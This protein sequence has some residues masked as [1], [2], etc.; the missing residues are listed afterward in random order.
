LALAEIAGM[1]AASDPDRAE[2]LARSI[3]DAYYKSL[4]LAGIARIWLQ[5]P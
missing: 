3:T 4:A 5:G 1:L 2:R